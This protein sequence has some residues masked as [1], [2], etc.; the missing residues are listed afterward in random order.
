MFSTGTALASDWSDGYN[1]LAGDGSFAWLATSST[2]VDGVYGQNDSVDGQ[3][4]LWVVTPDIYIFKP[5]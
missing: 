4:G 1:W 3:P 2:S 5:K